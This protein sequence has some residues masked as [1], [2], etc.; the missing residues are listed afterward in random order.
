MKTKKISAY[1]SG[2]RAETP[3][4]R[5]RSRNVTHWTPTFSEPDI[6]KIRIGYLQTTLTRQGENGV[7][8]PS[9]GS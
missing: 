1:V 2:L 3:D 8:P 9:M 4:F 7:D 5:I 6:K